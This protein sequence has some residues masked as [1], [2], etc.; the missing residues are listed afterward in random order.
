MMTL[1]FLRELIWSKIWF[2]CRAAFP[3]LDL[4]DK[5]FLSWKL[6]QHRAMKMRRM[7]HQTKT[8]VR[9]GEPNQMRK[10][11][12]RASERNKMRKKR[13]K[14]LKISHHY[15]MVIIVVEQESQ[16]SKR[17]GSETQTKQVLIDQIVLHQDS[18]LFFDLNI[19]SCSSKKSD[20]LILDETNSSLLLSIQCVGNAK[21]LTHTRTR[22][23]KNG[24][25]IECR[26][27]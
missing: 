17:R 25:V 21:R 5:K 16:A 19:R 26:N 1:H 18:Y 20:G 24:I 6:R 3:V 15:E 4:L 13:K 23:S 7:L 11:L 22:I 14:Q 10:K 2:V 8:N 27:G 12:R 9:K